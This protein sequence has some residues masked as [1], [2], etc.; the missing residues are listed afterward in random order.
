ML[1]SY[2]LEAYTSYSPWWRSWYRYSNLIYH[3]WG[4]L[5]NGPTCLLNSTMSTYDYVYLL[6]EAMSSMTLLS[7]YLHI[8]FQFIYFINILQF[9]TLFIF[10][11]QWNLF[12]LNMEGSLFTFCF[13][14][15]VPSY[16]QWFTLCAITSSF[17]VR[18]CCHLLRC[19][20]LVSLIIPLCFHPFLST[21]SHL[22]VQSTGA[23][24]FS[25][26]PFW[27]PWSSWP[28]LRFFLAEICS[29]VWPYHS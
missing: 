2:I 22:I 13:P 26:T 23:F 8:H 6:I 24:P 18:F 5:Y 27:L 12:I 9:K 17:L 21:S 14:F 7:Q 4:Y 28:H 29:S 1:P 20:A 19:V 3:Q 11:D 10:N 15:C 25:I 16:I